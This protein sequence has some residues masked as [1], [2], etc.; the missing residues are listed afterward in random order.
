MAG[1]PQVNFALDTYE[2][3]VLYP[4]TAG[5]V[6]PAE[7]VQRLQA[8]HAEHMQALQ[9]R[10]IIL[11]SGSIDGTTSN[12]EPPIGFGLA[13]TGSVEDV[14]SVVEANPA[15]Q[16]GL[17]RVDVLTFLC[18]AGSLEFPLVKAES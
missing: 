8:E 12:P 18:P 5:R 17:Y 13:R 16:A 2:C 6:L 11:V 1:V 7:T 3:I 4:G 14:R 10:G 15:V 9:R